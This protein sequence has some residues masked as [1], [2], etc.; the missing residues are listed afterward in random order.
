MTSIGDDALRIAIVAGEHSGDQLGY[1]LMQALRARASGSV[2]FSGVG[3]ER[4]EQEG[5]R[6]LFTLSDIAVMGFV[7]VIKRLPLILR[8]IRE[9]AD[10]IVA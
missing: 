7:P 5:L 10:A 4:M 3:G 9:T 1:K 2:A 6:S 8:R